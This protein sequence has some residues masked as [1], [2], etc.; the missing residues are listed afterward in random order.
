MRSKMNSGV[1]MNVE[2]DGKMSGRSRGWACERALLMA[3]MAVVMLGASAQWA[4]AQATTWSGA[5]GGDWGV[6]GNWTAGSPGTG[7]YVTFAATG[8]TTTAG[9][10]TSVL[11]NN[12]Q[13]A[14]LYFNNTGGSLHRINVG[15]NTLTVSN[16]ATA[17]LVIGGVNGGSNDLTG[18][19][20]TGTGTGA[21]VFNI[22]G[23]V[24]FQRGFPAVTPTATSGATVDF[25]GLASLRITAPNVFVG[26]TTGNSAAG[27]DRSRGRMVLADVSTLTA[28][29]SITVGSA[30]TYTPVGGT[31]VGSLTPGL[32]VMVLG[33]DTTFRTANFIVG[34]AKGTGYVV[35][36]P[37]V[38]G[39]TFTLSGV[40]AGTRA[41]LWGIGEWNTTGDASATSCAGTVDLTGVSVNA[42]VTTMYVGH[43]ENSA[44][45]GS[46]SATGSLTFDR[47]TIDATSVLIGAKRQA[48][49]T[50]TTTG[51]VTIG[52]NGG[53]SGSLVAKLLVSGNLT[54]AAVENAAPVASAGVF[55]NL[56]IHAGG[57]V[58][59][60][61]SVVDGAVN[62]GAVLAQSAITI[63]PFG[64]LS[65][66]GSLGSA[67]SPIDFVNL[68]GGTLS[69]ATVA[70]GSSGYVNTLTASGT[71]KISV[72]SG[73]IATGS[74]YTLLTFGTSNATGSSFAG[75]S[76][77][78]LSSRQTAT[79]NL[80]SNTL[81]LSI[82]GDSP[83]WTGALNGVW[84]AAGVV[85]GAPKN[86]KLITAGTT[87]DFLA[88]DNLLFDDT[89]TTKTVNIV[90]AVNPSAITVDASSDYVFSG[91][92]SITGTVSMVKQGSG[93]LTMSTVNGYNGSTTVNGG[94]LV[95]S[96][97]SIR[98]TLN[99][100]ATT[101][102]SQNFD[103][104][105]AGNV[106]S[107]GTLIKSGTGTA[108]FTGSVS[109]PGTLQLSNGAVSLGGNSA[110]ISTLNV[111]G[112]GSPAALLNGSV[113]LGGDVTY[114]GTAAGE[115]GLIGANVALGSAARTITVPDN[116][117]VATE[118]TISGNVSGA[119]TLLVTGAGRLLLSGNNTW[120]AANAST[121]GSVASL[122][123]D[124]GATVALG[125]NSS[126]PGPT[127]ST[128][129][130]WIKSGK[131][132]LNGFNAS[133]GGSAGTTRWDI[134]GGTGSASIDTGTGTVTFAGQIYAQS[135]N[136][137]A[138]TGV[139]GATSLTAKIT[140]QVDLGTNASP[141]AAGALANV[142]NI[143]VFNSTAD[144]DLQISATISGTGIGISKGG[145]GVLQLSGVNTFDGGL[146]MA[147]GF[148]LIDSD[149]ALGTAP[150]SPTNNISYS[151]GVLRL[152]G[153]FDINPNRS[154]ALTNPT[155]NGAIDT[156]GFTSTYGGNVAN[157]GTGAGGLS[158]QG[159]GKLTLSG[160]LSYVGAT[161]ASAGL[162]EVTKPLMT[163]SSLTIGSVS[164]SG[165]VVSS[166]T[167]SLNAAHSGSAGTYSYAASFN[168][169]LVNG[170][171]VLKL[172]LANRAGGETANVLRVGSLNIATDLVNTSS[173][174]GSVDVGNNDLVLTGGDV[175]TVRAMVAQWYAGGARNGL[176]LGSSVA[177][178]AGHTTLA[179]F[180]NDAGDGSTPYFTSYDG[181][182]G[183][184][185]SAIIVKYAYEGDL[186]LDGVVDGKDVKRAMEGAIF[187]QTGWGWGDVDYSGVVDGSDLQLI[188]AA[189]GAGLPS[190]GNGQ[191]SIGGVSAIPEPGMAGVL[192]PAAALVSRRRRK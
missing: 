84:D 120:G 21:V 164:G 12:Y 191:G 159:S 71:T 177:S 25:S 124:G 11:S 192:L 60:T 77:A 64:S 147:T 29:G 38:S 152:N 1:K 59:V 36:N 33:R 176:G 34:A 89:A 155:Q 153:S 76:F 185:A 137:I 103:G 99:N 133:G 161:V 180:L 48:N 57:T 63:N 98:G 107:A 91:I 27:L 145:S 47:G 183:L 20:F 30:Q 70:S 130:V 51:N 171:S 83:K 5:V 149:A 172:G 94:K 118:L 80:L 158:K 37:G 156:Q 144:V 85:Q 168:T 13:I 9:T 131:L 121:V 179:V 148:V 139:D 8:T 165:S 55:G 135:P 61:G 43:S 95:G 182:T 119:Q 190:L 143:T 26:R 22:A 105:Y 82:S 126:L 74:T 160:N 108:T 112:A 56:T 129:S 45:I 136:G 54:M 4:G 62:N 132:D 92:G 15:S 109:V 113:T 138:N 162:L 90:D 69:L 181:V 186:N 173:Y 72:N 110:S 88:G 19:A 122:T 32:G 106:S 93:T 16:T 175:A 41:T 154:I 73:P 188:L 24:A 146:H 163:S 141:A 58:A 40:T 81:T 125:S 150:S 65:V 134:G 50:S 75:G 128:G 10:V 142:R 114:A 170:G 17:T 7:S 23:D 52:S 28:S 46:H 78:G 151:G 87:T 2:S 18:V 178:A 140:G 86:W 157:F 3:G 174:A 66:G 127:S 111:C 35:G 187:G 14:S 6:A 79:L 97:A 123:I 115:S 96:T 184:S 49:T 68:N 166:A 167:V 101:E 67:A 116:A 104:T 42:L 39:A 53:G 189:E 100:N 117:N 44:A 102:F 31:A 169:V